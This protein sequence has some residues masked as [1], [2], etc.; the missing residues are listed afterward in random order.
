MDSGQSLTPGMAAVE[1]LFT[2]APL[3]LSVLLPLLKGQ[4]KVEKYRVTTVSFDI[5]TDP[6]QVHFVR[7]LL[8]PRTEQVLQRIDCPSLTEYQLV[9]SLEQYLGDTPFYRMPDSCQFAIIRKLALSYWASTV[10]PF[11]MRDLMYPESQFAL[12]PTRFASTQQPPERS[13]TYHQSIY[14]NP[15]LEH[16]QIV[17]TPNRTGKNRW[18]HRHLIAADVK[19]SVDDTQRYNPAYWPDDNVLGPMLWCFTAELLRFGGVKKARLALSTVRVYTHIEQHLPPLSKSQCLDDTALNSWVENVVENAPSPA[20]RKHLVRFIRYAA[21][22]PLTDAIDTDNLNASTEPVNVDAD[23][24]TPGELDAIL[25]RLDSEK[26]L[27]FSQWLFSRIAASLAFHGALRRGEILRLRVKDVVHYAHHQY[28]FRLTICATPEGQTKNRK[29]RTLYVALPS[30]EAQL[31]SWLLSLKRNS[32]WR[33]QPLL[34]LA[35]ESLSQRAL[36]YILPVTRAIKSVCGENTRFHHLRHGGA[37]VLMRQGI[38]LERQYYLPF[39]L[40]DGIYEA[41]VYS[42]KFIKARF[43]Y[44]LR[45]HD[46][47]LNTD[48]TLDEV[49]EMIGH[50]DYSTTRHHYLHGHDWLMMHYLPPTLNLTKTA[51]RHGLGMAPRMVIYLA[52]CRVWVLMNEVNR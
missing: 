13:R 5:S 41:T 20:T 34:A 28:V 3:P 9:T 6:E 49:L 27:C 45:A 43:D 44:W 24:V 19:D 11:L 12:P 8:L 30:M 4:G 51:V 2:L 38:S 23:L 16:D 46:K 32:V 42:Q 52:S 31:L 37:L 1:L 40:C 22:L 36:R 10:S 21:Q 35:N 39:S 15:V 25:A 33:T 14:A 50:S 17:K 26:P 47:G 18:E 29:R 48:L 7:Y